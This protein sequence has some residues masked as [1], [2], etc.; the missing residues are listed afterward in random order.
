MLRPVL[1]EVFT[2]APPVAPAKAGVQDCIRKT[3]DFTSFNHAAAELCFRRGDGKQP[4][5]QPTSSKTRPPSARLAFGAC[6]G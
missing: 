1:I 6:L 4:A 3:I 2:F 5:S